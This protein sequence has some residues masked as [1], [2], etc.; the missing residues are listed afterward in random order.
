MV[1]S[2]PCVMSSCFMPLADPAAPTARSVSPNTLPFEAI[3]VQDNAEAQACLRLRG[4][5]SAESLSGDE[6]VSV[7]NLR[8]V[9]RWSRVPGA[10]GALAGSS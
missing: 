10:T 3:N 6:G 7:V 4:H 9:A 5:R 2:R 8:N 1:R